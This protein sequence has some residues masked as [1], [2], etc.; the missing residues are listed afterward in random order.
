[1][2]HELE[3]YVFSWTCSLS[4]SHALPFIMNKVTLFQSETFCYSECEV[5]V[6][7]AE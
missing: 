7:D 6:G 5:L 1:M 4:V 3:N 2:I